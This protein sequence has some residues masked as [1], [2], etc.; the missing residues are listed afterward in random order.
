[1]SQRFAVPGPLR[2][3]LRATPLEARR[4]QQRLYFLIPVGMVGGFILGSVTAESFAVPALLWSSL[5]GLLGAG[6][7]T[8]LG[9]TQTL[10]RAG[11][12]APVG[13]EAELIDLGTDLLL[14]GLLAGLASW[15]LG[16]RLL[17]PL[18]LGAAFVGGL[19]V[20]WR[21]LADRVGMGIASIQDPEA[22][23]DADYSVEYGMVEQG[24]LEEALALLEERSAEGESHPAPLIRAGHILRD[25]GHY[26]R[27][28]DYYAKAMSLPGLDARRASMC[29][30]HIWEV[31]GQSLGDPAV[32]IPH[33]E[34]LVGRH[35][36]ARDVDW[37]WRELTVGMVVSD[38]AEA[39]G[40]GAHSTHIPAVKAVEMILSGAFVANASDIHLEDHSD[41]L[42]VRYRVDGILQDIE[43]PPDRIRAAVL[44]RLRVMAGLNPAQSP[45][46][47]DARI[48]VPFAGRSINLRVSTVPTLWGTSM[49]LRVLDDVGQVD[50]DGLGLLG[51]DRRRLERIVNR[52]HGMVLATGPGGSGKSTTLRA[53]V[54]SI[55]TGTE[56]I[57]TVEDPV[58]YAMDGVCQTSVNQKTGLTFA[59]L[60]RS[61]VRQDPDVL[62]VGEI[63][64][65]ETAEIATHAGLTGHLVLSTLHTTNA[66]SALHRLVDMGIPDYLVV[67]TL[68]AV[69]AQRLVRKVCGECAEE[70][71]LSD[72]E[73]EGL[74]AWPAD[75]RT[76]QMGRGCASCRETGYK[77]RIGVFELLTIEDELREAFVRRDDQRLLAEMAVSAGMRTLR[78]DGIAKVRAGVTTPAELGRVT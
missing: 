32:A 11:R 5:C 6:V 42:K 43:A 21:R 20:S 14:G 19:G 53:I 12:D 33:L 70:R 9:Q 49:A 13:R 24:Q 58:E 26:R 48:R 74:G 65:A 2:T 71:Q 28:V 40:F 16:W 50:L 56:K 39:D 17:N 37:A 54:R 23:D 75:L 77:G 55:A 62:L 3:L 15:A 63:R 18:V 34:D 44:S 10:V 64:D 68:E 25:R 46:P 73:I 8:L 1:V 22:S 76:Y 38:T 51:G 57:F 36:Q 27:S 78:D 31:A 59:S 30:R 69:M 66:L 29:A 4:R 67:H 47:E 72:S 7:V 61:L 41:G 52:P 35:P 60:L 45:G